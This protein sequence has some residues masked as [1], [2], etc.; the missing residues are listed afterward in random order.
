MLAINRAIQSYD[1][2]SESIGQTQI[3]KAE[4]ALPKAEVKEQGVVEQLSTRVQMMTD[5]AAHFNVRELG[6]AE[7]SELVS[8]LWSRQAMDIHAGQ[9]LQEQAMLQPAPLD[10]LDISY[11]Q[12]QE[13]EGYHAKKSWQELY[14]LM[15]NL[16]AA[17][18]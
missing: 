11:Q 9:L 2:W 5:F 6:L 13:Q 8:G 1:H 17:R 18:G 14:V 7:V 12:W 4:A 10:L 16:A 15:A 3:A